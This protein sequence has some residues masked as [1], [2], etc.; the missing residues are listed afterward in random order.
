[1]ENKKSKC[2]EKLNHEI[3]NSNKNTHSIEDAVESF[4]DVLEG[5]PVPMIL[6]AEDGEFLVVSKSTLKAT[7]YTLEEI[8]TLSKWTSL[9]HRDRRGYNEQFIKRNFEEGVSVQ[10]EEETVYTKNGEVKIWSFHNALLGKLKDGRRIIVTTMIDVTKER[11]VQQE[12][13]ES[14]AKMKKFEA[15]MTASIESQK[16][17][18][19]LMI[20]T[21]FNYLF[22]ND[23]HKKVMK[24]LYHIDIELSMNVLDNIIIKEDRDIEEE[25]YQRAL[26]G[27]SFSIRDVYGE[28]HDQYFETYYG[29][30]ITEDNETIGISIFTSNITSK[31][32][33]LLRVSESEEKFRLIYSAMSQGLAV[34][35]LIFNDENNPIDYT[36]IEV[37]DSYLKL[38]G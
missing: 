31:V 9:I 2:N 25:R 36:Y 26:M 27:E 4:R 6:H 32:K 11:K 3:L 38:F 14:L 16:D 29:P 19:I 20:D 18:A 23:N 21:G 35:E 30:I 17:F 7:G 13:S 33:E 34:H 28:K 12:L 10:G 24:E 37:N 5:A 1:M 15:L 8:D 22:F